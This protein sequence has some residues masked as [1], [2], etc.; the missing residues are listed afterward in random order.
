MWPL[1][2]TKFKMLYGSRNIQEYNDN[3]SLLV[4]A[5]NILIYNNKAINIGRKIIDLINGKIIILQDSDC[6]LYLLNTVVDSVMY[7]NELINYENFLVVLYKEGIITYNKNG[8]KADEIKSKTISQI[9]RGT[10][11]NIH[12]FD[13]IWLIVELDLNTSKINWHEKRVRYEN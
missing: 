9:V 6:S 2:N 7:I 1:K 4:G 5:D 13:S 11:N 8:K 3:V 12:M 10:D